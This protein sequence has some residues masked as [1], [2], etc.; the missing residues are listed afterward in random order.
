MKPNYLA[1]LGIHRCGCPARSNPGASARPDHSA[2]FDHRLWPL[3]MLA[4]ALLWFAFTDA[5]AQS[6]PP[7]GAS[8]STPIAQMADRDLDGVPDDQDNCPDTP[9]AI[10]EDGMTDFKIDGNSI[11]PVA[12]NGIYVSGQFKNGSIST[13]SIEGFGIKAAGIRMVADAL[14]G[15]EYNTITL[16]AITGNGSSLQEGIHL[17]GIT[18]VDDQQVSHDERALSNQ[19]FGNLIIRNLGVGIYE[20]HAASNRIYGNTPKASA[21]G[22]R[23]SFSLGDA[24]GGHIF[25][26]NISGADI[27]IEVIGESTASVTGN[28][29][30]DAQTG[31]NVNTVIKPSDTE[32][33]VSIDKKNVIRVRPNGI[34]VQVAFSNS[35]RIENNNI[36]PDTA[37]GAGVA[38]S[39]AD[40][41]TVVILN[42]TLHDLTTGILLSGVPDTPALENSISG[43]SDT[44]ITIEADGAKIVGNGFEAIANSAVLYHSGT[45]GLISK[46]TM[47][48]ATPGING[49]T[50]DELGTFTGSTDVSGLKIIEQEINGYANGISI[51]KG[52]SSATIK[53]SNISGTDFGVYG[54]SADPAQVW[55]LVIT[56]NTFSGGNK[57]AVFWQPVDTSGNAWSE[58]AAMDIID[59]DGDGDGDCGKDYLF[60]STNY[61]G[62]RTGV[63]RTSLKTSQI[64][65]D[66]PLTT[67]T[68]TCP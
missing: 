30:A 64:S 62:S 25:I 12:A 36:G 60:S 28:I 19:V 42:N 46:N 66:A 7:G 23:S 52:V 55:N 31:V 18:W 58:A 21:V 47:S 35:V 39:A 9:N 26:N 50:V 54:L 61:T 57:D 10:Q 20:V 27:G 48:P 43:M 56:G 45:N 44:G 67:K 24:G 53:N 29:I 51:G 2:A 37:P 33:G 16:N 1:L 68:G 40:S 11:G 49:I 65:D 59:F 13:N 15:P 63:A 6:P 14:G 34:G 4:A 8:S 41:K 3:G 32:S 38:I 5:A 22:I 17:E